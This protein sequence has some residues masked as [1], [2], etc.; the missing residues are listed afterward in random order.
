MTADIIGRY[1]WWDQ[2]PE[3][4][5]TMT[6]LG[7]EGLKPGGPPRAQIEY[8]KGRKHRIY[9]LYDRSEATPKQP[10]TEAQL[11]A[12]ARG[13]AT[14]KQ[15]RIAADVAA[16]DAELAMYDADRDA[17]ILW[18][19]GLMAATD[20]VLLD[21]E[22]TGL[23]EDAEIIQLGILAPDGTVLLDQLLRPAGPI[24]PE[25]MAIHGITDAMVADAPTLPEVADVVRSLLS[26]KRIVAYNRAFDLQMWRQTRRRYKVKIGKTSW[27]CAMLLYADFCG[28]W[29][30]YHGGYRWQSLPGGDHTAIGDCRAT[31][32]VIKRM[33][34]ARLSREVDGV[35]EEIRQE[36]DDEQVT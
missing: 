15:N 4:L 17:A 11:D 14:A 32:E 34:R 35:L 6:Q 20:W 28:E 33:A 25:A 13:R 23:D 8:G 19:R 16:E 36:L 9:D 29:S 2:V 22:T 21:T 1:G 27:T 3:N 24:P 30:E 5:N 31:L 18:A 26:G 10:A 12:L 7:K